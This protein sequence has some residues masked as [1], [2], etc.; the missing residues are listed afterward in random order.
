MSIRWNKWFLVLCIVVNSVLECEPQEQ[1]RVNTW[2]CPSSPDLNNEYMH[3]L[4]ASGYPHKVRLR[5]SARRSIHVMLP[6]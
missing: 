6:K 1:E 4:K 5:R 2:L 3:E